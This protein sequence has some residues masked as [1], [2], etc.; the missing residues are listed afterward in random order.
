MSRLV[1]Q[2]PSYRKYKA[3]VTLNGEEAYRV[4]RSTREF[5]ANVRR[6]EAGWHAVAQQYGIN[7]VPTRFLIDRKGVLRSVDPQANYETLI[8]QLLSEPAQ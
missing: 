1:N 2:N 4:P 5:A 6:G 3:I 7:V 8:P